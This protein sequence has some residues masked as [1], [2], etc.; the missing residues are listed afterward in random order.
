MECVDQ[1]NSLIVRI[2]CQAR[3]A[4]SLNFPVPCNAVQHYKTVIMIS[5]LQQKIHQVLGPLIVGATKVAL[6]DFPSHAN[7]G[8]SAIWMGE[9]TYL[10]SSGVRELCFSSDV[11]I[12]VMAELADKIGDGV[13][14][15]HGG[16]NFGDLYELHQL[17]RE[18][19]IKSFPNNKIIQLPQSIYFSAPDALSRAQAVFD[20]HPDFTMLVRDQASLDY[21][22]QH[23]QTP[24]FLCPDMAFCLGQI[25]IRVQEQY[26]IVWLSRSDK[27]SGFQDKWK[28]VPGVLHVDW[29][30]DKP[31]NLIILD[32]LL[33]S[34]LNHNEVNQGAL[35]VVLTG[36]YDRLAQERIIRGCSLLRSGRRVITDRLHAH[37]FCLLMGI[38][39]VILDNNYGKLSNYYNTWTKDNSIGTWCDSRDD[40][41]ELARSI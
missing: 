37:I 21:Y 38:P 30:E 28:E 12:H 4:F 7:C 17:F 24:V 3:T 41:L 6:L 13:I 40:A 1:F 27:E 19:I 15:L 39:H 2:L 34:Q 36:L 35:H 23:F 20:N 5:E 16:G 26:D 22:S 32:K 11:H 25:N 29:F 18:E 9:K 8:D 31:T 14:L 10:G 33:R